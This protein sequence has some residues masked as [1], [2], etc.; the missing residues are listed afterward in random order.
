MKNKHNISYKKHCLGAHMSIAGGYFK[1]LQRG[2]GI[3]CAAIQIFSKNA[4]QWRAKEISRQDAAAFKAERVRTGIGPVIVHDSYLINLASPDRALY[5]KSLSAF[6]EEVGRAERLG[7]EYLV[8]HP[9]AHGAGGR[10]EGLARVSKALSR[11]LEETRGSPVALLLETTAGQGT[12]LG[13]TFE[14]LQCIVEGVRDSSR[15]GVCFDTCHAFAAGYDFRDGLSY[16][17]TFDAFQRV[18][19]LDRLK[20]FHFNDSKKALGSRVD[21][22][23][24]IGK[25]FLGKEAFRLILK[26]RRFTN[27]PKILE[28]PKGPDLKEDRENLAILNGLIS[29][30]A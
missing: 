26:D 4:S 23:A 2:A 30:P 24:H 1:A 16:R 20:L 13:R 8:F 19:G 17:K 12:G 29:P 3:G 6:R 9:G 11:V 14:E 28:T 21:R 27:I 22:H 15:L 18:I 10:E 5:E 25:G 7:C